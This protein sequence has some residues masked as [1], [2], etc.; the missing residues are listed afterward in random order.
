MDFTLIKQIPLPQLGEAGRLD[1]RAEFF[2]ILNNV[3][4]S[5]PSDNRMIIFNDDG[6]I[7]GDLGQITGAQ[8]GREIQFGLKIFF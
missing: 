6:E 7:P 1:F 3:N 4:F 2:N 5:L 8:L